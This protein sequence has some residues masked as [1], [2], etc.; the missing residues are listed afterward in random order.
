M[1][2]LTKLEKRYDEVLEELFEKQK[3]RKDKSKNKISEK[4]KSRHN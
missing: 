2:S 1:S 3:N 4:N